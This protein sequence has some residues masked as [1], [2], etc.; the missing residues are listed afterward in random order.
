MFDISLCFAITNCLLD[1]GADPSLKGKNGR[2]ILH[3][4]SVGGNVAIIEIMLSRGLDIN[5]KDSN[6]DTPLM[7]ATSHGKAEAVEY[8]LSRGGC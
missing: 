5:S 3:K 4:A 8:L 1:E 7:I 2:N 6:G